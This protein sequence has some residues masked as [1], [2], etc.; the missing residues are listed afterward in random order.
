MS[1]PPPMSSA[2][3][4]V[5]IVDDHP[6]VRVGMA[7]VVNQQP[8]MRV[9]AIGDS[10]SRALELYHQ[11]RP[12]VVL[13]DLRLRGESGVRATSAIRADFP[14]ARVLMISNYDGDE[15]IHQA[16]AA[17]ARGYLFKSIVE[18]ELAAYGEG[19]DDKP[20]LIALN[21]IDLADAELAEA[22]AQELKAAGADEV[23]PISGAT[24][25]GIEQLLD[26][27]LGHLPARTATE[28][29]H[30]LDE[31]DEEG[32]APADWSPI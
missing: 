14:Q 9:A 26:A 1:T 20:R 24:G 13:M 21:K 7:T 12:D 8:D 15:N 10:G 27:V 29:P 2:P 32:D 22:F 23:F 25:E 30:S 3:I 18:D 6:L 19:L 11:H 17:G 28:Q 4:T 31:D 5:L 16:L